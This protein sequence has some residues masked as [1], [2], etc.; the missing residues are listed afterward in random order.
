ME[1]AK[2]T[3]FDHLQTAE[4][5]LLGTVFGG[6]MGGGFTQL[7]EKIGRKSALQKAGWQQQEPEVQ[8][9][10]EAAILIGSKDTPNNIITKVNEV[11]D[12]LEVD[13]TVTVDVSKSRKDL[14][15]ELR[16]MK[17]TDEWN[18]MTPKQRREWRTNARKGHA[19]R[20]EVVK[21]Q[22]ENV[23]VVLEP[24]KGQ[25][26]KY[27]GRKITEEVTEEGSGIGD[28]R[29]VGE[30]IVAKF[31]GEFFDDGGTNDA[32]KLARTR[33]DSAFRAIERNVEGLLK[34]FLAA[35]P[36]SPTPS[37]SLI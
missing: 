1:I 2:K 33:K 8:K 32:V 29:T 12:K 18:D 14:A 19:E 20:E 17:K 22:F 10:S 15:D 35:L 31:K 25:R 30:R 13:G 23:G 16:E 4:M 5:A 21:D 37:N 27:V 26:G 9:V 24:V 6:V 28:Q 7:A 3:D 11:K 34:K 36:F